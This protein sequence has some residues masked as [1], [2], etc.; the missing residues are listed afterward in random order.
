MKIINGH[1]L[2]AARETTQAAG[3]AS[4]MATSAA[5]TAKASLHWILS[6]RAWVPGL[7]RLRLLEKSAFQLRHSAK[8]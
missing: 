7:A 6:R 1:Q 2:S 5:R 4:R 3:R 8:L